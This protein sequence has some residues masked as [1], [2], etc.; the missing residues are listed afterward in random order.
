M[1]AQDA[2]VFAEAIGILGEA[3]NEPVSAVRVK[4][5]FEDLSDF[6]IA[7]VVGA[8][9]HARRTGKYFPRVAE[10]R[11]AIEGTAEDAAEQAWAAV[12]REIRRVGWV[13]MPNLEPR[14]LRAVNELWGGWQRL[15]ETLPGEGPEL[16]GW[17]KQ[18]KATYL[19]VERETARQL[20]AETVHPNVRA[21]ITSEQKRLAGK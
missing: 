11:E 6:G 1:T 12:L 20:T 7:Q 3:F 18:F 14:V 21:F 16:V 13:G 8:M 5:Y 2:A 15:C 10:L 4:A 19:S 9:R 17:I